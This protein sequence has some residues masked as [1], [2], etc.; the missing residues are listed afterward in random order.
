MKKR[1]AGWVRTWVKLVLAVLV[2]FWIGA[3]YKLVY[4]QTHDVTRFRSKL[5]LPYYQHQFLLDSLLLQTWMFGPDFREYIGELPSFT[6]LL[7]RNPQA[8]LADYAR[9]RERQLA[10]VPE[11]YPN[12]L[13]REEALDDAY[14]FSNIGSFLGVFGAREQP[15]LAAARCS[16]EGG[17]TSIGVPDPAR[18][19]ELARRLADGYPDSPQAA[20]ALLSVA[21]AATQGADPARGQDL[22][23]R[24]VAE[25]PHSEQAESAANALYRRARDEGKTRPA[26]EYRRQ[27][28][29]AAERNSRER[30]SGQALPAAQSISVMGYRADLSGL[31]LQ[32]E[33]LAQARESLALANSYNE[34]LRELRGLDEGLESKLRDT[35]LQLERARSEVWVA[36]LFEG[37]K[38]GLPGPPPRPHE[39]SVTGRVTLEGR[40]L[41][42]VM[43]ALTER[44]PR[45]GLRMLETLAS[46][47]YRGLTDAKGAY[48][49]PSVPPDVYQVVTVYPTRPPEL[50]GS[51][52]VPATPIREVRV[53][54]RPLEIPVLEFR[55]SLTTRTYGEAPPTGKAI[56]LEWEPWPGAATYRVEVLAPLGLVGAFE[57][58]FPEAEQKSFRTHRRLWREEGVRGVTADCPLLALAPD[59]PVAVQVMQY[60]YRVTAL[61]AAEKPLG[62]SSVV[63]SRFYL[64][65]AARGA[66]MDL[67][68]PTR[69]G[70]LPGGRRGRPRRAPL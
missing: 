3:A 28:L 32:I 29:E 67:K 20:K 63:L 12:S 5:Q 9:E 2:Y 70:G 10:R 48:R 11:R 18:A 27:A 6:A 66:L 40:P 65:P 57:R 30:L 21:E 56:R 39:Q 25:Y 53:E 19:A 58:R 37:L 26:L 8:Y 23:R 4:A 33:R 64:S 43:V 35:R 15:R 69:A 68:P 62:V 41:P 24:I 42:G 34:R 54:A 60:D 55:K 13:F 7:S 36:D 47:R 16:R 1:L 59:R 52:V 17:W 49:I 61:D 14:L 50:G 51:A 44:A 31:F 22:Y 46:L 45:Q 38:V